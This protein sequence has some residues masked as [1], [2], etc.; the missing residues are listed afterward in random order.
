MNEIRDHRY[1]RITCTNL[2]HR[3]SDAP[4]GHC[5]DCGAVVN[6]RARVSRCAEDDH[7]ISRR[8]RSTFCVHCG[9]RLIGGRQPPAW[10]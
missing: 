9:E 7:A 8:Q 4:V 2:N 6:A 3:R 10:S 5:P 1:G